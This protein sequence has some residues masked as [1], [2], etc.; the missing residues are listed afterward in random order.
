VRR[1]SVA[2]IVTALRGRAK[3]AAGVNPAF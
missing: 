2:V 1:P 3:P